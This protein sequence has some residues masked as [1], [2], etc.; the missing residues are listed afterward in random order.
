MHSITC[1]ACVWWHLDQSSTKKNCH[2]PT[3]LLLRPAILISPTVW[4]PRVLLT[5]AVSLFVCKHSNQCPC[6]CILHVTAAVF[7]APQVGWYYVSHCILC[8][9]GVAWLCCPLCYLHH[10]CA[11]AMSAYLYTYCVC[12]IMLQW[13]HIQSLQKE[14]T[15]WGLTR[16]LPSRY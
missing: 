13:Q 16:R 12:V 6:I 1:L 3:P 15:A 9:K 5:S 7:S 14:W 2:P 11:R 4:Q 10:S 8:T